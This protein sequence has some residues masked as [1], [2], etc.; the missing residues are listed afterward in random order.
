MPK[1]ATDMFENVALM[2]TTNRENPRT[3]A[4]QKF[5]RS[6]TAHPANQSPEFVT[7]TQSSM[8][9]IASWLTPLLK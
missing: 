6:H 7:D 4:D 1:T 5:S 3:L 2:R 9:C 8:Q